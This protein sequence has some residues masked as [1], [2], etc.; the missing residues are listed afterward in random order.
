MPLRSSAASSSSA[1]FWK[2]VSMARESSVEKGIHFL[3]FGWF[4]SGGAVAAV[5]RGFRLGS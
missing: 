2:A 5:E 3:G 1:V 4:L